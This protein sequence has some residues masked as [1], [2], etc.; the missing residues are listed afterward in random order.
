[1]GSLETSDSGRPVVTL[2]MK[3]RFLHRALKARYRD[4]SDEI[5]AAMSAL[6]VGDVAVDV[7][8]NK[9]AYL[10][11]LRRAVGPTGRVF[12][13]EPQQKL[14]RYLQSI[15]AG[16]HWQN[17]QVRACALSDSAGARVLHI[18]GSGDSPGASLGEAVMASAEC[19]DERVET[20]TLDH[21]L[22][23]A[24][25]VALLKVDV[26]GH[27]LEVLRGAARTLARYAPLLLFEC[28]ARHLTS[29]SMQ[30]VFQFLTGAGYSGEFF[31]PLGLTPIDRFDPAVHQRRTPGNFWEAPGYCNNFIFRRARD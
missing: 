23:D 22:A 19:R 1:M 14:A 30:D 15:C 26:E 24:G 2:L 7:G 5:R 9:G 10:Y 29:H 18:P 13:Y 3:A 11:W 12:A 17:V 21:Q 28:E 6:T 31:S 4:Q 27:E 16:M 25:R 20:D 8:A